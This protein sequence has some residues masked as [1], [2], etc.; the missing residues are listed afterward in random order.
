[1]FPTVRI[2]LEGYEILG[3]AR[4]SDCSWIF[5]NGGSVTAAELAIAP[6][7]HVFGARNEL[8]ELSD[9]PPG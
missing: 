9:L 3:V 6:L 8:A 1:M 7:A 5:L 2:A 4:D